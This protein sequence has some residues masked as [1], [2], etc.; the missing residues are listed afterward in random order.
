[1]VSA[2]LAEVER[3]SLDHY[4]QVAEDFN[5]AGEIC[6]KSGIQLCYHNHDFEFIQQDGKY[7]YETI[8]ANTDKDLVKFEMDMYWITK[9]KQDAIALFN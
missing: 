8:L 7:P 2:W 1:M 6:K 9:A 3:G 5:K 4:K